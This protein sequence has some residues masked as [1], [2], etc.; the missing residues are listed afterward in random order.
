MWDW[1]T[2]TF[3]A[4][5]C[6]DTSQ[7]NEARMAGFKNIRNTV[8]VISFISSLLLNLTYVG[9]WLI[10]SVACFPCLLFMCLRNGPNGVENKVKEAEAAPPRQRV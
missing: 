7:T 6:E 10:V 5:I 2:K 9:S 1:E 4:Q 3:S 8:F